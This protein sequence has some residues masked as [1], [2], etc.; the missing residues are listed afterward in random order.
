MNKS[1]STNSGLG[2][3]LSAACS[4]EALL[5]LFEL[6]DTD[7]YETL[8]FSPDSC[9]GLD[10]FHEDLSPLDVEVEPTGL[11]FTSYRGRY[12]HPP[13]VV[14]FHRYGSRH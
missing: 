2:S 5:S 13:L 9:G 10:W 7:P 14:Q 8:V 1:A 12:V 4:N 6:L 11:H 3:G